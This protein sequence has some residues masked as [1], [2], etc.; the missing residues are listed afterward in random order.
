M[1]QRFAAATAIAS[2]AI[3]LPALVVLLAPPFVFQRVYPLPLV[4]CWLPLL[5][6]LWALIVPKAWLPQR[7]PLWG[8]ILGL[9][10]G[11]LAA[12]VFDI[13]SRIVG[14]QAP[15]LPRGVGVLL[16]AV[17]YYFLWMLVRLA[18]RSLAAARV[19]LR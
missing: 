10:A 15:G 17:L 9:I 18:Y 11:L 16:A 19:T 2:M 6:G 13:P 3:A 1:L 12:F 7:L 14:R 5:W 8:A 4:W